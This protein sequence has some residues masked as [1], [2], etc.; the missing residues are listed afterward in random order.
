MIMGKVAL[1]S[2]FVFDFMTK[3]GH[4]Q[5]VTQRSSY[6]VYNNLMGGAV[7]KELS[8]VYSLQQMRMGQSLQSI[9]NFKDTYQDNLAYATKIRFLG[10]DQY[11][12]SVF[13][14]VATVT[15]LNH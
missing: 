3:I 11:N 6:L 2:L 15:F 7:A 4:N 10:G 1:F 13:L 5:E 9:S 12:V 14:G 8:L